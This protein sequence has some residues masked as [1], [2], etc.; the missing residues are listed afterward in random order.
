MDRCYGCG[1][2][3]GMLRSVFRPL[4][5]TFESGF[6]GPVRA[7]F[8]SVAC[9]EEALANAARIHAV[10]PDTTGDDLGGGSAPKPSA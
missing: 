6:D 10:E 5:V 1:D 2:R 4:E 7:A 8:C 3:I 9:S